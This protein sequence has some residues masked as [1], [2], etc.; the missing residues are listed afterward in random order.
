MHAQIHDVHGY[1]CTHYTI[2]RIHAG[3]HARA[4]TH[5]HTNTHTHKHTNTHTHAHKQ[6]SFVMAAFD[7]PVS[8]LPALLDREEEFNFVKVT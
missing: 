1:A 8:E 4:H 5:K 7:V 6:A 3:K 2:A